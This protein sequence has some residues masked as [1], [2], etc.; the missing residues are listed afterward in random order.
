MRNYFVAYNKNDK[1]IGFSEFFLLT[2]FYLFL[3]LRALEM[4]RIITNGRRKLSSNDNFERQKK[5]KKQKL[6]L[7]I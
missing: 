7:N 3:V 4:L 6:N 1:K 2:F 5:T